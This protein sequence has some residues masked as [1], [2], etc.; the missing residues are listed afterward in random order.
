[1][2]SGGRDLG[3]CCGSYREGTKGIEARVL[4]RMPAQRPVYRELGAPIREAPAQASMGGQ[5]LGNSRL[6][7]ACRPCPAVPG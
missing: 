4:P 5:L 2:S 6:R 3:L 1:M 7:M